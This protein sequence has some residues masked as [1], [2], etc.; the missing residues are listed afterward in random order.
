VAEVT[1]SGLFL[2]PPKQSR[3]SLDRN[4][5]NSRKTMPKQPETVAET[6]PE[7]AKQISIEMVRL[8]RPIALRP[9]RSG[10]ALPSAT[11]AAHRS[12]RK[13]SK[14]GQAD[15]GLKGPRHRRECGNAQNPNTHAIDCCQC[16]GSP[17]ECA[18]LHAHPA[19]I[20]VIGHITARSNLLPRASHWGNGVS[21][22][23]ELLRFPS[24]ARCH[25]VTGTR[26][27]GFSRVAC[28]I[29]GSSLV[30]T[31]RSRAAQ[32]W[33]NLE[34]RGSRGVRGHLTGGWV[35]VA[36][37][38]GARPIIDVFCLSRAG[39]ENFGRPCNENLV[40]Q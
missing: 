13:G 17:G 40:Y 39:S 21:R 25:E 16:A 30:G 12:I 28:H 2:L 32:C 37:D 38:P 5:R 9:L 6:V 11:L 15:R 10:S 8:F 1:V 24:I 34:S 36:A 20:T 4:T 14:K 33:R 22:P 31:A 26:R 35:G 18:A 19:S 7:T 23:L 27:K 29:P 3:N